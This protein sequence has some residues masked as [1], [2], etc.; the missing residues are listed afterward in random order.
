MPQ[1]TNV[2]ASSD[3]MMVAMIPWVFSRIVVSMGR[4]F[5]DAGPRHQS[6]MK[7]KTWA[8]HT[9]PG[10]E[11][12]GHQNEEMAERTGLE[13]ATPGVTSRYSNQLN[14]RSE[15]N[16]MTTTAASTATTAQGCAAGETGGDERRRAIL[17]KQGCARRRSRI[18]MVGAEGLEP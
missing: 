4:Y 16:Q 8:P 6:E 3:R 14:Y 11:S 18:K 13:P 17:N 7:I 9:R 10:S 1:T 5:N 12:V 2:S 15:R